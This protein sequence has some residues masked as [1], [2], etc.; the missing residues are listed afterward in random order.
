[1][2]GSRTTPLAL[3]AVAA[4]IALTG[5]TGEP[6]ETVT[7]TVTATPDADATPTSAATGTTLTLG[8][9]EAPATLALDL[10]QQLTVLNDEGATVATL[11]VNAITR[12]PTCRPSTQTQTPR[13]GE[14]IQVDVGA[15]VRPEWDALTRGPFSIGLANLGARVDGQVPFDTM[16]TGA[17]CLGEDG[18]SL[19][20]GESGSSSLVL[21]VP[22][23]ATSVTISPAGS[24]VWEIAVP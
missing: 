4:L 11:T 1:M 8:P 9:V 17:N 13:N 18:I 2:P 21:D 24:E 5:C 3:A 16:G 6:D 12:N 10:G 22:V 23:G 19:Q 14:Y 20:P 7:E 15:T